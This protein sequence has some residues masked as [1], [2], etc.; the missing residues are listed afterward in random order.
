MKFYTRKR[1]TPTVIIVSLIDILAILLI[2]V[3]VTTTFKRDQPAV[4]INLP[5]SKTATAAPAQTDPA[6]LT[7]GADSK[8]YLDN[9]PVELDGL[10][11]ALQEMLTVTPNRGLA[12]NAD[13]K[14]PFGVV[15]SVMDVLKEANVRNVPAFTESKP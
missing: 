5:E 7:I 14:A 9:Q 3:I 13:K 2:F 10:K 15:V 8:L 1:R 6:I 12:L 11:T 4:V